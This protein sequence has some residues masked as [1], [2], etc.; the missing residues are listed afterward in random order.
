MSSPDQPNSPDFSD[1]SLCDNVVVLPDGS[2]T[3]ETEDETPPEVIATVACEVVP[4][5]HFLSTECL[6]LLQPQ[7]PEIFVTV[8][9]FAPTRV[10]KFSGRS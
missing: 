6:Q 8:P 9:E 10:L 1:Y 5:W 7:S 2:V 3:W 4:E